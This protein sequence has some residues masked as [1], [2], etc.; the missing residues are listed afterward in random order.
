MLT[1]P[2]TPIHFKKIRKNFAVREQLTTVF[3]GAQEGSSSQHESIKT[4]N[5]QH[6]YSHRHNDKP[7]PLFEQRHDLRT[8]R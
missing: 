8:W 1:D 4:P 7:V 3:K 2:E 5:T 6:T